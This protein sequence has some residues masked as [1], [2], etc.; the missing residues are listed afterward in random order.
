MHIK[1][2]SFDTVNAELSIG[3]VIVE[4][5][6]AKSMRD[7]SVLRFGL[8]GRAWC[9][10][11]KNVLEH[12]ILQRNGETACAISPDNAEQGLKFGV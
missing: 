6:R 1:Q 4:L 7:A 10:G 3:N 5:L 8:S 2:P 11:L 12:Q 9:G